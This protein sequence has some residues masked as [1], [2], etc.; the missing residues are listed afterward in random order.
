MAVSQDSARSWQELKL[1]EGL[2]QVGAVAV[3]DLNN[4]WVGGAEGVFL[5]SDNG[6]N[7][8]PVPDLAVTEV[9]SIYFDSDNQRVLITSVNSTFVFAVHLPDYKVNY[10]A[11]GWKLRFVR[12]VGDHLIGATLYDGIVLQ[13]LMV[14]SS[15]GGYNAED[16]A[17]EASTERH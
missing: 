1:P 4:L 9:D 10:W 8:Q 11:A 17:L 5:S 14:D 13:P 6:A 16:G 12:P 3:D 2:T 7:W 15:V